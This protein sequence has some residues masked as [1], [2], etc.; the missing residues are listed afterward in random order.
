MPAAAVPGETYYDVL[1]TLPEATPTEIKQKYRK[2]ALHWHPDKA[3]PDDKETAE[4]RFKEVSEAYTVLS[5]ERQRQVY[6][7]YLSCRHV[8]VVEVADPDDPRARDFVQVSFSSWEE[9][10]RLIEGM[11]K[12]ASSPS[13]GGRG[14]GAA[15]RARRQRH[16]GEPDAD[17]EASAEPPLSVMECLVAGGVVL[18]LWLFASWRHHSRVWLKALPYDICRNHFEYT[19]PLSFLLSPFFFGNVPFR[20]AAQWMQSALRQAEMR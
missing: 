4:K 17:D 13:S 11:A 1:G 20:D 2:A 10:K 6:D 16:S 12:S 15:A 9:F 5:D 8:G 7:L 18:A 14:G 19:V 3:H